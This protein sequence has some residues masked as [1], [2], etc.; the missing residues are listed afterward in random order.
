MKDD[1]LQ[2]L[3]D[4]KKAVQDLRQVVSSQLDIQN[5]LGSCDSA[6]I[7]PQLN[8]DIPLANFQGYD[9]VKVSRNFVIGRA[10]VDLGA[11][12]AAM[13]WIHE[14]FEIANVSRA[15]NALTAKLLRSTISTSNATIKE[16]NGKGFLG[17][18]RSKADG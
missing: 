3:R 4:L 8:D 1:S 11:P 14:N 9:E 10:C 13:N 15:R 17:F 12:H 2:E 7:S 16:D 6:P 5:K 18:S